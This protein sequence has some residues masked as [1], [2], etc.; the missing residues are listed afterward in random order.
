ML[1]THVFGKAILR[2]NKWWKIWLGLGCVCIG[3]RVGG[4]RDTDGWNSHGRNARGVGRDERVREKG[5]ELFAVGPL[6]F[7]DDFADRVTHNR[8]GAAR[9]L[10]A[11]EA[12]DALGGK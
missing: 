3:I 9:T 10:G 2:W 4:R 11:K 8:V 1:G 7:V 5:G 6:F 12:G